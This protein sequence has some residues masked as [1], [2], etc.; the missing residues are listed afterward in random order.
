VLKATLTVS[1]EPGV[2]VTE[3]TVPGGH[4]AWMCPKK[5]QNG[6]P[7]VMM[8]IQGCPETMRDRKNPGSTNGERHGQDTDCGW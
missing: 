4:T 1:G 3:R 2:I 5:P 8:R 7:I 6:K